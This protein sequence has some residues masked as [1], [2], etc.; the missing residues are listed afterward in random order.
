MNFTGRPELYGTSAGDYPDNAL[1]FIFFSKAVFEV[2]I[3]MR[4]KPDVI[5]CNDWQT[6]LIP[7]YLKT[8]YRDSTFFSKTS[9]LFTVHNLGYQGIFEV[10]AP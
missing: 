1:R 3:A 10:S 4:I 7:L 5:H 6:A 2:C 9:T 8:L